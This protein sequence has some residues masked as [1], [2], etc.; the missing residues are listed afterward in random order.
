M[1]KLRLKKK[2]A[3]IL[4]VLLQISGWLIAGALRVD[5][6]KLG[7]EVFKLPYVCFLAAL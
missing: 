2:K 5:P 7:G 1:I 4:N 6:I 3:Y